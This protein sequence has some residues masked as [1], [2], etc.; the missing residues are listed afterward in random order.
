MGVFLDAAYKILLEAQEPLSA[1]DI[2]ERAVGCG[3]LVSLGKTPWQ[4]MKSKLSTDILRRGDASRF[5]RSGQGRFALREWEAIAEYTADRY[6]KA[7]FDEDIIVF[8]ASSLP[9]YA[10][11]RGIHQ[12]DLAAL[13]AETTTMRR[14]AA[15]DDLDVVQ[16]VSAFIVR[17]GDRVLTHKRTKRLPESRLHG[18]YS[19]TFGGHLNPDDI[20]PLFNISRAEQWAPWLMRELGEELKIRGGTLKLVY[21]GLLYDDSR[22]VSRQH[23]GV[24]Y[25]VITEHAHFRIGERGFLTDAKFETLRDVRAR[26][27][28][29]ENW[30]QML[31]AA[32]EASWQIVA[33][34]G[35]T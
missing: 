28:D 27:D 15:E 31:L 21:R 14:A 5:M 4:T 25:E 22:P 23:V 29:F 9:K 34:S 6:Q 16:L 24:T 35:R 18:F 30:S 1:R 32:M 20:S 10:P 13:I 11:H 8:P 33:P 19:L 3:Y 17:D 2:T 26:A 7:L 12:L